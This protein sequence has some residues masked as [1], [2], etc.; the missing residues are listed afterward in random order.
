MDL[1]IHEVTDK[2]EDCQDMV[3]DVS[4]IQ[5]L[6]DQTFWK[7]DPSNDSIQRI[8]GQETGMHMLESSFVI[9]LL[10]TPSFPQLQAKR[11]ETQRKSYGIVVLTSILYKDAPANKRKKKVSKIAVNTQKE[12][13]IKRQNSS[14]SSSDEEKNTTYLYCTEQYITPARGGGWI[15]CGHCLKWALNQCAGVVDDQDSFICD[16]CFDIPVAKIRK[17]FD[18]KK[19][20][21]TIRV[22]LIFFIFSNTS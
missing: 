21:Y 13:K 5:S 3:A 16:P 1:L 7:S 12:K 18:F 4:P 8:T 11:S 20:Y 10:E 2:A 22:T 6:S 9:T 19:E 14:S 15:R 17:T